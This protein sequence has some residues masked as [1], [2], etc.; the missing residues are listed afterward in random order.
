MKKVFIAGATGW[1]GKELSKAIVASSDY[2]LVG[3]LSR[4]EENLSDILGLDQAVIPLFDSIEKAIEKV[5]YDILIDFTSPKIAKENIIASIKN[6]KNSIVGTSG[7]SDLEYEEIG[8]LAEEKNV[9]VLAAGNFSITAVLLQRFA[10]TAAKY[11]DH[12][13]IIDYASQKK[14]DAPSGTVA[15]LAYRLSKIQKPVLD[16]LVENTIGY[17]ETRGATINGIQVHAVRL[18]GHILGV[19]TIFG[20]EDERLNIKHEAG[21]GAAPYLKGIFIALNK[22]DTFKGLKRGLDTV[23]DF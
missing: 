20:M 12:F 7:L 13:E 21:S 4:S 8:S 15:E 1:V 23:M 16:V 10:E 22:I 11:I 3:G 5:D 14:V 19:E 2:T 18:P 6:G 17:K 9:S